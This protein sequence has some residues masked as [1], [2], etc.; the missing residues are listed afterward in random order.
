MNWLSPAYA[1][2]AACAILM[3]RRIRYLDARS[4]LNRKLA[5]SCFMVGLYELAESFLVAAPS[6]GSFQVSLLIAST[7]YIILGPIII[8]ALFDFAELKGKPY[9]ILLLPCSALAGI[10]VY[11]IWT[12]T[13]VIAGFH[14][15]PWGNVNELTGDKLSIAVNKV[16]SLV[17]AG[18]GLGA[19]VY[20]WQKASSQRYRVI[21]LQIFLISALVNLWGIF[22]TGTIW[23]KWGL[24]DPTG[25]GVGIGLIGYGFLIERYKHLS[26]R[27][28]D[29]AESLLAS[30]SGIA[31]FVDARGIVSMAPEEA[32]RVLGEELAGQPLTE[33]LKGWP[34]LEKEWARMMDDF[35]PRADLQGSIAGGRY[36]LNMQPHRNP[37]DEFDG[38]VVRLVPEGKLEELGPCYGL[39]AR[40]WEVARLIC[41][42]CD[43]KQIAEKLF[44]SVATVKSHLHRLYTKTGTSGQADLIRVILSKEP[45]K[46]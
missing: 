5:V 42:G 44:I 4:T 19:L 1:F 14:A 33:V 34:A 12:G 20:A 2:I 11:Q 28:P 31:L 17:S 43:T 40:E 41:E 30:L 24:P 15:S 18:L 21:A 6:I 39:T 8:S 37:F 35:Q 27:Q 26:E 3:A 10:Q 9:W 16:G 7:V 13:W 46:D 36:T 22:A 38:A 45:G 29:I 23:M 32:G 25:L